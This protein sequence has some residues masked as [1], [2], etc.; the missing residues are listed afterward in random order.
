M[1]TV[2]RSGQTLLFIGDSI[3]DCARRERDIPLGVG[4][5]RM[6][7]DLLQI[8]EPAKRIRVINRGIG[9]NT[10]DQLANRWIDHVILHQPDWLVVKIG[11]NDLSNYLTQPKDNPRQSTERFGEVYNEVISLVRKELPATCILLV[12]PFFAS[13][14]TVTRN[15]RARVLGLI[16]EYI[17]MTEQVANRHGARF[18]NLHERVQDLIRELPADAFAED[19][20][21]TTTAGALFIAEAVYTA[22]AEQ[23]G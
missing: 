9:G 8:R 2:L 4:Y 10:I 13:R 21:H 12:S 20:V 6:L 7:A 5:V 17:R 11:I 23:A 22:L 18:L 14:D 15:Y 19:A 1:K 3:T 16:G